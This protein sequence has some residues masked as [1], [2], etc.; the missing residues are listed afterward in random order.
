MEK[1]KS[2][3]GNEKRN[4]GK[5]ERMEEN[6]GKERRKLRREENEGNKWMK[7]KEWREMR[8]KGGN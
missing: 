4:G 3:K 2:V 7:Q 8:R 1:T 6:I 5:C